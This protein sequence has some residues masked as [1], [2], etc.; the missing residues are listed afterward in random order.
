[1]KHFLKSTLAAAA[2]AIATPALATDIIVVSH[3]QASDPFWSVV[4][5]GV[6]KA[7]ADTG[8]NVEYRAPETFDMVAMSQLIDA[9]VN[10]EPDGIVVSIP[11]AD[12]LGPSI[13][14]A[15]AAGI[16]VISMNS[17]SNVSKGLGALLHVGQEEFDAG[18]AAGEKMAEMGGTKALCVNHEVGNV[19]LDDRCAGFAE[20]FGG[21]VI[22]LPTTND[23]SEIEAKV[24]ASLDSDESIDTVM[25]LGASLAGEPA[26]AAVKAVGGEGSIRVG[27]F[28]LSAGF[29]ES[30]AAGE[31]AFAID[32]QQYLQGYLPV[33]FLALH[34]QY[35]LIPG[36]NVPSGPNLIT[37][38]K[39]AQVV[40][41]SA[42]GIR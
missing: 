15:V 34:A 18:K 19:S 29:L 30:V 24:K 12:A 21:E 39:A 31:A 2:L 1:M 16:A 4:K 33:A 28:D 37:A 8:A 7:A 11:D 3:G 5:N 10:Q 38:D 42:K 40:E 25:A 22:V 35:G 14:K 32:Q 13:E 36:G 26:V 27:S 20:G 17:G 23:P 6:E 9:A 41:L